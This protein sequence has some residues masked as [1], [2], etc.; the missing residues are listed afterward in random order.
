MCPYRDKQEALIEKVHDENLRISAVQ[1][2]PELQQLFSSINLYKNKLVHIKK[3]MRLLH[4][5]ST[6]LQV[7]ICTYNSNLLTRII[8]ETC[9]EIAAVY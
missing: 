9:L 5:K 6:K 2:S 8:V 1:H 7:F 3:D 4:E